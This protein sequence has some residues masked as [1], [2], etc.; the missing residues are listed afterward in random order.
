MA[1]ARDDSSDTPGS[2]LSYGDP[3]QAPP[4]ERRVDRRLRGRLLAP[5]TVWTAG[6]G[7][8][9]AGLTVSSLLVAEGDPARLLGLLDPLSALHDAL[10]S[11]GRFLVHVLGAGDERLAALFAGRLPADPFVEAAFVEHPFGPRLEGD[12]HVVCCRV[13]SSEPAGFQVLVRAEIVE[14]HLAGAAAEPLGWYR[15]G[16]RSLA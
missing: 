4:E 5:V 6:S 12:R 14:V 15:G 10:D 11:T 8:R 7:E 3:F 16:Y 1:P 9:R 2:R 13:D